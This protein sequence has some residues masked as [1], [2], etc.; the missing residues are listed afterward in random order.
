[1][2]K[3]KSKA[4]SG[5]AVNALK[6]AAKPRLDDGNFR[7]SAEERADISAC[8]PRKL[9]GRDWLYLETLAADYQRRYFQPILN[10]RSATQI[11]KT[12]RKLALYLR[13]ILPAKARPPELPVWLQV[14]NEIDAWV[15]TQQ[16]RKR[17]NRA[18]PVAVYGYLGQLLDFYRNC[19]GRV[20]KAPSSPSARFVFAAANPVLATTYGKLAPS[21]ISDLIRRRVKFF[22]QGLATRP[23][24]GT[25]TL[26]LDE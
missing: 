25:P 5:R 3:Y 17:S 12:A 22:G 9:D 4:L 6:P 14:L 24:L 23:K 16:V 13:P 11:E 1:M 19:G 21:A 20:G 18:W 26:V 8:A 7:Y 2:R 15:K 10:K